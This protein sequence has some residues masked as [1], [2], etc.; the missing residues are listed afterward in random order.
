[1]LTRPRPPAPGFGQTPDQDVLAR[2][3]ARRV[4]EVC[5]FETDAKPL[6]NAIDVVSFELSCQYM[7]RH[8]LSLTPSSWTP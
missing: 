5:K 4:A 2:T 3:G 6:L 8:R 7:P 1:M